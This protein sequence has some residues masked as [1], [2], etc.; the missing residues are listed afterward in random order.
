M[1]VQFKHVIFQMFF[2]PPKRFKEL[3][4]RPYILR[5]TEIVYSNKNMWFHE[6]IWC[7]YIIYTYHVSI[8]KVIKKEKVPLLSVYGIWL[9][10]EQWHI[11]FSSYFFIIK[12]IFLF[13][14][15]QHVPRYH[16]IKLLLPLFWYLW[17]KIDN[18]MV[19][20][21]ESNFHMVQPIII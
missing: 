7:I 17:R 11:G 21:E 4:K 15:A 3:F 10:R 5:R 19:K 2:L 1:V 13:M 6:N 9:D 8:I 12:L 20:S 16:L 18:T 14:R